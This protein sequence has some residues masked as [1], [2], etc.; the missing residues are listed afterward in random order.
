MAPIEAAM[1]QKKSRAR[2][3]V[4]YFR[5]FPLGFE[6]N[7]CDRNR[8]NETTRGGRWGLSQ[9]QQQMLKRSPRGIVFSEARAARTWPNGAYIMIF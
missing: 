2:R 7:H 8:A 3:F 9:T 5:G 1:H 6:T 4:T